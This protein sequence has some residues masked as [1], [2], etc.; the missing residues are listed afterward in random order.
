MNVQEFAVQHYDTIKPALDAAHAAHPN[1]PELEALHVALDDMLTDS[2]N[3]GVTL[4]AARGGHK[5]GPEK[6]A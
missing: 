4:E 5:P 2:V 6:P 1:S 3:V